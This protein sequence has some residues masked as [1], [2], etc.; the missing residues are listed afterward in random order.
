MVRR[1]RRAPSEP[2]TLLLVASDPRVISV[3]HAA[4]LRM[5]DAPE[6]LLA[7]RA[8]ALSRLVGPG[9]APRH[10]VIEGGAGMPLESAL[11]SA[12][13]DRFSG[14]GVV[15][16]AP[17]G[18]PA[19][20][21]LRAVPAEAAPLAAALDAPPERLPE[22]ES[23]PEA[24]AAGLA[25][26]EITVR[27][28][29]I[30][31]MRD[32]RPVMVEALARWE[33]PGAALGPADFVPM[34]EAAGL[35]NA[36]TDA[37]SSRALAELAA[38]HTGRRL[39]MSF[40]MPLGV[41][42]GSGLPGRLKRAVTEAGLRPENLLLEL[43]ES[44]D[45]RDRSALRRALIRLADAGFGVLLDDL[46]LDD[47]RSH[48]LDLPF[49]GVKLDR[50][51]VIALPYAFRARAEVRRILRTARRHDMV[52]IAEG[53]T[54]PHVWRAAAALGC[55]CAQGFG[56]GRPLPIGSLPAWLRAWRAAGGIPN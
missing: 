26:G 43:T 41:M 8:E 28:Q 4:A 5:A 46:A 12:A 19:P 52:V 27:F 1:T 30:V 23:G 48:L 24:L 37:V 11:L 10:L 22:G 9:V 15:V 38:L 16:V 34:A 7:S 18:A 51:L 50:G 31:R 54:D 35:A 3:T 6:V 13:R 33:R 49:A 2:G 17:Q 40:N 55:E 56:I 21:G 32:R 29:P 44:T 14:T 25:R 53:V 36:L 45:V 20:K 47:G 39:R 42:L